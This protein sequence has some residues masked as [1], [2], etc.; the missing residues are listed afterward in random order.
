MT[1]IYEIWQRYEKSKDYMSQKAILTKT[2]KNWLMYI[3]RQW[4]AVNN[5]EGMEDLQPFNR[6]EF[7]DSLFGE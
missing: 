3:G 6:K 4:E 5:S 7:V 2:E 1:D